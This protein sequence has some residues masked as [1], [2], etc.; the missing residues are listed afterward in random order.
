MRTSKVVP[1]NR[2]SRT[3]ATGF[4]LVEVITALAI[5]VI[6]GAGL[7]SLYLMS[8]STWRDGSAQIALQMKLTMALE[9]MMN[10]Q[11]ID[12][13]NRMYGLREAELI[14]VVEPTRV[15]FTNGVDG[16]V[17]FFYLDGNEVKYGPNTAG[18][19]NSVSI[20][21]PSRTESAS[22]LDDYRTDL[23]FV[24][25]ANGAVTVRL[26]AWSRLGERWISAALETS[27]APRN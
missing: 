20:Y 6:L 15:E 18:D 21:D 16:T 24:Q 2:P 12:G 11:R 27:A 8:L 19:Q 25:L 7:S 23:E 13:E 14:Q 9:R 26:S 22:V 4:T 5:M 3:A 10:G 17:R 1:I